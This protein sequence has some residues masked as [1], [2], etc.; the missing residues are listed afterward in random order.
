M[1]EVLVDT[2]RKHRS[3]VLAFALALVLF[4]IGTVQA[5]GFASYD[6][7]RTILITA[8]FIGLVGVGQTLCMLTGGIDLSIPANLAGAAVLTAFLA[9]GNGGSLIWIIPMVIAFGAI[10]G[11]I[12]GLGVAYAGVPPIIMTL[13]MNSAIQGLLLIYTHGGLAASA[14]TSLGNFVNGNTLGV[15]TMLLLWLGIAIFATVLLSW[16]SFGRK[17]YAVGTNPPAARLAG[18]DVRRVLVIPYVVS[19]AGAALTGVLLLG[20]LGQA[21]ITMGDTY[22]F[23]SAVAVAVGGASILGGK[24]HY[25]GTVAG[26]IILTLITANLNLISLGTSAIDIAYGV[27][28][29]A[30]VYLATLRVRKSGPGIT[31]FAPW[32]RVDGYFKARR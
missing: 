5:S 24:G 7:V 11:L 6:H 8:S 3:V 2:L 20:Y 27:I 21:F 1:R 16:S 22:L 23:S 9:N 17:L 25:V 14:P 31:R 13:G 18:V 4:V 19:G 15:S 28:L 10:I 30:T 29:L 32:R 12:N 26:A